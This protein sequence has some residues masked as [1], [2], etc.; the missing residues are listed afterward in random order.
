MGSL[1][2]AL[3]TYKHNFVS[4]HIVR[5]KNVKEIP[6][7][8]AAMLGLGFALYGLGGMPG[9]QELS[10]LSEKVTGKTLRENLLSEPRNSSSWYDGVLTVSTGLDFQNRLSN[11]QVLPDAS[12][13]ALPHLSNF[14]TIGQKAYE[15]AIT[16]DQGS[17]QDLAVAATPAGMRGITEMGLYPD[18][19]ITDKKTGETRYETPR[20]TKEQIIRAATGVRPFRERL[21]D[22]RV[23]A[24][25]KQ[26]AIRQDK[27]KKA[28][29][30]FD[31]AYLLDDGAG[32]DKAYEA[33][34]KED[35]NPQTLWDS[36]R[37]QNLLKEAGKSEEERRAGTPRDINSLRRY[38]DFTR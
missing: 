29:T 8:G 5:A 1:I 36:K 4:Q 14:L 20:S 32:M 18:G 30:N 33:Y 25:R 2:G 9:S 19:N 7:A 24:N 13:S 27:L 37:L 21:Q 35:G 11:A 17:F 22:E 3:S 16:Q 34:I 31:R 6:A 38:E 15:F 28:Q 10:W 23:Y 26:E 12:M